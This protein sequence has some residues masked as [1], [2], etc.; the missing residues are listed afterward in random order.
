M[1]WILWEIISDKVEGHR[2]GEN[3]LHVGGA[4]AATNRPLA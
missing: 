2:G 3:D 4:D 1:F